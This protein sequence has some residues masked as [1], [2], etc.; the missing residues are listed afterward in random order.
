MPCHHCRSLLVL[1]HCI[2]QSVPA[3]HSSEEKKN[4][5]IVR[6][7]GA[8]D[9]KN[10]NFIETVFRIFAEKSGSSLAEAEN[11]LHRL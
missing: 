10:I 8:D 6:S 2:P 7:H 3:R 5:K 11:I 4:V 9:E 1:L